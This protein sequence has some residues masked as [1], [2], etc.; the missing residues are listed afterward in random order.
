ML[1]EG[2][3]KPLES[4][5]LADDPFKELAAKMEEELGVV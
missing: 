5:L 2:K 4:L 1:M 3:V